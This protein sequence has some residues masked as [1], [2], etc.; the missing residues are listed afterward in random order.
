MSKLKSVSFTPELVRHLQNKIS[1]IEDRIEEDTEELKLLNKLFHKLN[2]C[3]EC[4][5]YG[6]IANHLDQDTTRFED[7][8]ACKGT[9]QAK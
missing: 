2:P 9:G 3:V 7:C 6:E 4:G 5:G 1:K 8:E